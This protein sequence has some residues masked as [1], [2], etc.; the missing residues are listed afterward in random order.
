MTSPHPMKTIFF[1]IAIIPFHSIYSQGID[2]CHF[3]NYKREL[4]GA[5]LEYKNGEFYIDEKITT[6]MEYDSISNMQDRVREE[7][8]CFFSRESY[9]IFYDDVGMIRAE[10]R[11]DGECFKGPFK[12]YYSNGSIK[13]IGLYDDNGCSEKLGSWLSY[14]ERGKLINEDVF[15]AEGILIRSNCY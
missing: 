8:F 14:D 15:S 13:T 2:T 4:F 9:F 5:S 10:G 1:L 12:E 7:V 3:T 6:E 11:F